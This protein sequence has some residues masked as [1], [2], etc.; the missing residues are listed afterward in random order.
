MHK[1]SANDN[2]VLYGAAPRARRSFA[3]CLSPAR[4]RAARFG[5][6]PSV[7][8]PIDASEIPAPRAPDE[9][10]R[11][12]RAQCL[13]PAYDRAGPQHLPGRYS[14]RE[15]TRLN[16][17]EIAVFEQS[18]NEP[19]RIFVNQDGVRLCQVR[20]GLFAGGR[21]IRTFSSRLRNRD[22]CG[23]P[24]WGAELVA[25]IRERICGGPKVRSHLSPAVSQ[26]RTVP[27]VGQR[28]P[29]GTNHHTFIR[30]LCFTQK[31]AT[32]HLGSHAIK[33]TCRSPAR[34]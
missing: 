18:T 22:R 13:E 4:R 8:A 30:N 15:A 28:A 2:R 19:P 34:L 25:R 21:W 26:Q 31:P 33:R 5:L 20:I 16:G 14:S 3:I 17:T 24:S 1:S 32:G 23:Q 6:L 29:F 10:Y 9:R 11:R 27:A 12:G 7:H